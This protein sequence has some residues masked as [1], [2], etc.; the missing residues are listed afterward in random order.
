MSGTIF[1]NASE[2]NRQLSEPEDMNKRVAALLARIR[3]PLMTAQ[4]LLSA[5]AAGLLAWDLGDWLRSLWFRREGLVL[6]PWTGHFFHPEGSALIGYSTAAICLFACA[7]TFYFGAAPAGIRA[8][9]GRKNPYFLAL[10]LFF[11]LGVVAASP[12]LTGT[13]RTV[14]VGA[15]VILPL[16]PR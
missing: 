10:A 16:V 15:A 6:S 2:K 13:F 3:L 1:R 8:A 12:E 11:T 7:A 5:V 4:I 14:L 9:A